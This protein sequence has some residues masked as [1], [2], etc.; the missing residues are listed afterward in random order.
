MF[1]KRREGRLI[2]F[3]IVFNMLFL[4]DIMVVDWEIVE[5]GEG[6]IE[7]FDYDFVVVMLI[8]YVLDF[9][10]FEKCKFIVMNKL[11]E[12]EGKLRKL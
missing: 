3:Y 10:L 5:G 8:V 7:I 2:D 4:V 6:V 1:L 12:F 11:L 9:L